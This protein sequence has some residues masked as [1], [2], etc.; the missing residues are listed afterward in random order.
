MATFT[1][2]A[3]LLALALTAGSVFAA[4]K[5]TTLMPSAKNSRSN[6]R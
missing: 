3:M 1:K 6:L 5:P 4:A 2:T